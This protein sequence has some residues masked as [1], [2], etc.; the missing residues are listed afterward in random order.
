MTDESIT[1]TRKSKQCILRVPVATDATSHDFVYVY[2]RTH[3]P[4]I[5]S[6]VL[7]R[8]RHLRIPPGYVNVVIS[9]CKNDK[10][11]AVGYD[12]KGRKQT[13]YAK[14]FI[15]KQNTIKFARVMK[16]E[17]TIG[18]IQNHVNKT[19]RN[20]T[21]WLDK[22]RHAIEG[23]S[24]STI[25]LL[26][27]KMKTLQICVIVKLMI[28]CNFRIG[29]RS[30]AEKY[31]SYG[32][33]TIEW[34]H[35][36]IDE[37]KRRIAFS[38]IGKKGVLNKAVCKDARILKVITAM[39][40]LHRVKYHGMNDI[41]LLHKRIFKVT[42]YDVNNY[43]K[44]FDETISSKDLRT[45]QANVLFMKYFIKNEENTISPTKR[46]M[47]ALKKVAFDLHNTVAVCKKSYIYPELLDNSDTLKTI[48]DNDN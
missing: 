26:Q 11:Q 43:L 31:K 1:S 47:N 21:E 16:L 41:V 14:W 32:L 37:V 27:S 28:L 38:F 5:D 20:A 19:I 45:W 3:K 25:H 12:T 40:E 23:K 46:Q 22:Y 10:I 35:I 9:G 18:K 2:E 6:C 44:S 34:R 33:T 42:S 17:K 39:Y 15:E 48:V 36:T 7:Q 30:N 8:I 24:H 13:M 4:V 29:N